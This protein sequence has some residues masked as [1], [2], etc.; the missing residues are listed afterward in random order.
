MSTKSKSAAE[1][2]GWKKP[3][4][5]VLKSGVTYS[6]ATRVHNAMHYEDARRAEVMNIKPI[7]F[8]DGRGAEQSV[9]AVIVTFAEQLGA[10]F[11]K[12]VRSSYLRPRMQFNWK[13]KTVTLLEIEKKEVKKEKTSV[14][15]K[16]V[17]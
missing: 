8:I 6:L 12:S 5:T 3:A 4:K 13:N 15:S 14:K 16:K 17:A 2:Q 9:P 10:K 1:A 11:I 7:S